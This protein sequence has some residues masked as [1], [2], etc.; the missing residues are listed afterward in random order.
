MKQDSKN[1][2]FSVIELV[3][4]IGIIVV[5]GA[6]TLPNLLG[7]K[8]VND[9]TNVVNQMSIT[10]REAQ[11]RAI[12][13]S[14]GVEWGVRF[15]N[16]NP[17]YFAMFSTPIYDSTTRAIYNRLPQGIGY[18]TSTLDVN[19]SISV[20]FNQITGRPS[21]PIFLIL[22]ITR[23]GFPSST[24]GTVAVATSGAVT[25]KPPLPPGQESYED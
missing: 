17:P 25:A 6:F 3:L 16:G 7:R 23:G 10:L 8:S 20:I 4:V 5:I 14:G 1:R 2:G 24:I 12:S 22:Y 18:V 13:Q 15:D 11:S 9:L 19:A 21:Q